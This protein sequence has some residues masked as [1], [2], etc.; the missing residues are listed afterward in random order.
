MYILIRKRDDTVIS[1]CDSK[2]KYDRT[3]L[4]QIKVNVP[5]KYVKSFKENMK[6]GTKRKGDINKIVGKLKK[7]K[8]NN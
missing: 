7:I 2:N 4:S 5:I 1:V 3:I 6:K 8:V